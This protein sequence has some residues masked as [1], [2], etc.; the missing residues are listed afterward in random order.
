MGIDVRTGK[1]RQIT[2]ADAVRRQMLPTPAAT[3]GSRA[4]KFYSGGN[5]SLPCQVEMDNNCRDQDA[6]K[7]PNTGQLNPQFVSYLMGF[8]LD[9]CDMPDEQAE[10]PQTES[11]NSDA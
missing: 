11:P 3:D 1:K 2:L 4:P 7:L 5:P 8:P 9:W 6:N 10:E